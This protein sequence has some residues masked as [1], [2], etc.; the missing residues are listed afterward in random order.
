MIVIPMLGKSSRFFRAGYTVPKYEL[1]LGAQSLFHHAVRS[2]E[3]YFLDDQFIFIIRDDLATLDF[4]ER[5]IADLGIV[6]A[7]I[8]ALDHDTKGQAETVYL[9]IKEEQASEPLYIFNI[10]TIRPGFVKPP[11]A[12]TCDGY[13]EVVRAEGEHWSFIET[14]VNYRVLRTTEKERI[15]DYCSNGL[16]YFREKAL[17]DEAFRSALEDE[18]TVKGEY[19]V[20][21]LYNRLINLGKV[22]KYHLIEPSDVIFCGT[23]EEYRHL[24]EDNDLLPG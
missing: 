10:D 23:P 13:L 4:V 22:I 8:V 16:Y 12:A 5:G 17:F 3:R 15:S 21:P 14:G 18:Q 24:L 7:K 19:Y 9:G 20:A 11:T 6:E 1:P 2:F